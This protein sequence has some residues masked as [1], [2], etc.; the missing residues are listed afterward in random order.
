MLAS[1]STKLSDGLRAALLLP[2]V[3]EDAD[4]AGWI[5]NELSGYPGVNDDEIPQYR[6][7]KLTV[8][9]SASNGA[10]LHANAAVPTH[11]FSD[12]IKQ[13]GGQTVVLRQPI[14]GMEVLLDTGDGEPSIPWPAPIVSLLNSEIA[15]GRS[16]VDATY[17]FTD[18]W[19]SVPRNLI[20]QLLEMVRQRAI[21]ELTQRVPRE[22]LAARAEQALAA[23]PSSV[24]VQGSGNQVIVASPGTNAVLTVERGDL[25]ALDAALTSLGIPANELAQLHQLLDSTD[26]EPGRVMRALA[27]CRS[28]AKGLG[29]NTVGGAAATLILQYLGLV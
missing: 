4:V 15:R 10:W 23:V 18:V 3:L 25:R 27:W 12:R 14:G 17:A 20:H 8:R 16:G 11:T 24:A 29:I 13:Y 2:E 1:G 6:K 26:D 19:F 28:S 5:Q 9:G 22:E 7:H 21:T